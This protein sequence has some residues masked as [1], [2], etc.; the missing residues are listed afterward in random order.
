MTS[1]QISTYRDAAK[2][3][4]DLIANR[5]DDPTAV[6]VQAHLDD[7]EFDEAVD[8]AQRA[9]D[10]SLAMA[11]RVAEIAY[12]HLSDDT[13]RVEAGEGEDHD[14]GRVEWIDPNGMA[15]VAWDSGV[16][17]HCPVADLSLI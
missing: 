4:T 9:E 17:T 16:K 12:R 11:I 14:T 7:D 1:K 2:R 13:L 5:D 6:A 3:V 10:A 8:I 15:Y